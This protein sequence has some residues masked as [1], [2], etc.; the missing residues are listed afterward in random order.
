VT[1]CTT[2][3]DIDDRI[4]NLRSI[5]AKDGVHFVDEGYRTLAT[6]CLECLNQLKSR[7]EVEPAKKANLPFFLARLQKSARFG[8]GKDYPWNVVPFSGGGLLGISVEVG[9][10]VGS[11]AVQTQCLSSLWKMVIGSKGGAGE[12]RSLFFLEK[13]FF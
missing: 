10:Q 12:L 5:T 13:T 11:L 4:K 2:T 6:R 3:A 1:N 9:R 7:A 8:Q